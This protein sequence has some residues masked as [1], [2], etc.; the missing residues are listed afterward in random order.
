VVVYCFVTTVLCSILHLSYSSEAVMRLNYQI[1]QKSPPQ[2]YCLDPPLDQMVHR[3]HT[4]TIILFQLKIFQYGL[5]CNAF[6]HGKLQHRGKRPT[7]H[8]RHWPWRIPCA[9]KCE[10]W[11]KWGNGTSVSWLS[12]W[13]HAQLIVNQRQRKPEIAAI[14]GGARG[15]PRGATSPPKF[16]LALPVSP[17]KLGLF[18]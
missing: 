11:G 14:R 18:L 17:P 15:V 13:L 5:K 6:T 12:T 10:T 9:L 8:P 1:L 3:T 4:Q 16:C 2:T 7:I